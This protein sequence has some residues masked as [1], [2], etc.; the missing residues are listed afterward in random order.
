MHTYMFPVQAPSIDAP[1][2][3][4]YGSRQDRPCRLLS[5]LEWVPCLLPRSQ[6][7]L[8]LV[9]DP[10]FLA[11]PSSVCI[12]LSS[13]VLPDLSPLSLASPALESQLKLWRPHMHA[14]LLWIS[15]TPS[16]A[17]LRKRGS[18]R[19]C[20]QTAVRPQSYPSLIPLQPS[21]LSTEVC[22]ALH[23]HIELAQRMT[24]QN[25]ALDTRCSWRP[26]IRLQRVCCAH[27]RVQ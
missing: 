17:A 23:A 11:C 14:Q 2:N 6:C 3:W 5:E 21:L 16:R 27:P 9:S 26:G 7:S 4:G 18:P 12:E 20:L 25:E 8:Q 19:R 1:G 24:V 10:Y 13:D 22:A 15:P